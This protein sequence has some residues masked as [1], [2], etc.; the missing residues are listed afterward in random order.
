MRVLLV[1]DGF[2]PVTGGLEAHVARLARYLTDQGHRVAVVTAAGGTAGTNPFE[3]VTSSTVLAL[4]PGLHRDPER[5]LPPPWPDFRMTKAIHSTALRLQ[6][7]VIHAHGWSSASASV[8]ARRL[9]IPLVVTLHDYGMLCP[10]RTLLN[11]GYNCPYT[12]G[13]RC[14][15][16]SDSD[17]ST[18]KR[19]T[20]AAGIVATRR[21]R[22][23]QPL[24]LAVSS[25]VADTHR[26]AG[27]GPIGVVPN[28][29]DGPERP[30]FPPTLGGP[31][32]FVGPSIPAK[33][34]GVLLAAHRIL[35]ERGHDLVLRH[36]GGTRNPDKAMVIQSGRLHGADLDAAYD[37]A[38][39]VVVPSTWEE[40]CPT[41]ALEAM[42]AGRPLVASA[43]GG[44]TDIV[45]DG[46]TGIL[47]APNDPR[48]L[49][50][51]IEPLLDDAE[52]LTR[53]GRAGR[54]RLERFSTATVGPQIEDA[55]STALRLQRSF[56]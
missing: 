12:A 13:P 6:P 18:P 38:R 49:A 45:E 42:A 35:V 43:V 44:L 28:F 27:I 15:T 36:V 54:A 39:L 32:L 48:A 2:P 31:I 10:Q 8:V 11:G 1:S 7:D 20:L 17:Q 9:N 51:G 25:A 34:L 16:C 50:D 30:V 29:I 46:V 52:V 5:G 14:A 22:S 26:R 19:L 21:T 4:V 56:S 53:M 41:V 23:I 40:P 55:Y 37:D 47:V 24:Y 33:G 3:I